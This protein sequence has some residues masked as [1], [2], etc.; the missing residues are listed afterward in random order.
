MSSTDVVIKQVAFVGNTDGVDLQSGSIGNTIKDSA[1]RNSATR[2]IMLRGN[3]RD[4]DVKHNT[5]TG[6]RVGI[7]VNG[8]VDS[9][10]KDN[11]ISGST[12]AGIRF[13]ATAT[14]NVVKD[15]QVTSNLVGVEFLVTDGVSA[16]GNELTANLIAANGCGLKGPTGG[17]AFKE[18]LFQGNTADTCP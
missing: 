6:N 18:N 15:N 11:V 10:V 5:F 17:N 12:L 4:N 14:G 1:F 16:T 3:T 8:A 2:G 9:T 13:G 7:L